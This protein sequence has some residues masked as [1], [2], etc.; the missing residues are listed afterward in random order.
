MTNALRPR[1][2]GRPLPRNNTMIRKDGCDYGT[3]RGYVG[4]CG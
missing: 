4:V 3:A 2:A 1:H